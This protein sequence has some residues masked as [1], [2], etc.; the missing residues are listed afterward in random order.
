MICYSPFCSLGSRI[1][2]QKLLASENIC[3]GVRW[4]SGTISEKKFYKWEIPLFSR[5]FCNSLVVIANRI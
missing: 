4:C 5:L 2:L 3:D 1:A